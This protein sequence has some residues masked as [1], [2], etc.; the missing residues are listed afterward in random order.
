MYINNPEVIK[1]L[2]KCNEIV[3]HWL[4]YHGVPIFSQD[5]YYCYF[6]KTELLEEKLKNL[7]LWLKILQIF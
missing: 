7:P 6:S 2:Y 4:I 5:K 3:A 1:D